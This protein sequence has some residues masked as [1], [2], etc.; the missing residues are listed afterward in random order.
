MIL[1]INDGLAGSTNDEG[2]E[3][4]RT[5]QIVGAGAQTNNRRVATIT[6]KKPGNLFEGISNLEFYGH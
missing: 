6:S 5:K 1:D 3:G 4:S 2:S